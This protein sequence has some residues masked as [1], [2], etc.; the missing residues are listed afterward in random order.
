[1]NKNRLQVGD[2]VI[3]RNNPQGINAS[4]SCGI[5]MVV[6]NLGWAQ[7]YRLRVYWFRTG[8]SWRERG[9]LLEKLKSQE[10]NPDEKR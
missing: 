2:L 10:D 7:T 9:D 1:M 5:G 6:D 3:H 4:V 8:M